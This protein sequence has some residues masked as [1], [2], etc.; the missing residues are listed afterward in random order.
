MASNRGKLVLALGPMLAGCPIVEPIDPQESTTD[1]VP[2]LGSCPAMD[3]EAEEETSEG[4]TELE[5]GECVAN[6]DPGVLG[7]RHQC[8]GTV[9]FSLEFDIPFIAGDANCA[10]MEALIPDKQ[11][12]DESHAFGDEPY[13]QSYVASCCGP[14]NGMSELEDAYLSYCEIDLANQLCHTLVDRLE[15]HLGANHFA[16]YEQQ[17]QNIIDSVKADIGGCTQQF[18]AHDAQGEP[19]ALDSYFALGNDEDAWPSFRDFTIRVH[20]GN[21]TGFS[22]PSDPAERVECSGMQGNDGY[23]LP[24]PKGNA[25]GDSH[26]TLLSSAMILELAGPA[27]LGDLV[28][29]SGTMASLESGCVAPWCS[30]ATF[31]VD[32]TMGEWGI[33]EMEL[34][35]E[36][37]VA[38][39]NALGSY[40]LTGVRVVLADLAVGHIDKDVD[41]TSYVIEPEEAYFWLVGGPLDDPAG[42]ERLLASNSTA[43]MARRDSRT[44]SLSGFAVEYFE[45]NGDA[46]LI[47]IPASRWE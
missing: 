22:V 10:N 24:K 34:F 13:G 3:D 18:I 21:I 7:Y 28:V 16:G 43:I 9:E 12:C 6:P 23:T 30:N 39:S 37:G 8:Q 26:D 20:I 44:W 5:P 1:C 25:L 2:S 31:A 33:A 27:V 45:L 36:S 4:P 47:E 42:I 38:L 46:W 35:A 15:Y 32:M 11:L 29:G 14:W 17:A 40:E 41:G 19:T